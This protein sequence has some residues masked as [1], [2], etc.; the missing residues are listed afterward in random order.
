ME[1]F[2]IIIIIIT[3]CL[4]H[5]WLPAWDG[6]GGRAVARTEWDCGGMAMGVLI[7]IEVIGSSL[8]RI[9]AREAGRS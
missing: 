7:G 3:F 9:A 1:V 2:T 8:H 6:M 4:A 5:M